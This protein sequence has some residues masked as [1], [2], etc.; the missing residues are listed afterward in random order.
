[1]KDGITEV[2]TPKKDNQMQEDRVQ[3]H[4]K[5]L[6][7]QAKD[8][9]K[10]DPNAALALLSQAIAQADGIG[11]VTGRAEAIRLQGQIH[12]LVGNPEKA[13]I[14]FNTALQQFQAIEYEQGIAECRNNLGQLYLHQNKYDAALE[15]IQ[16]SLT[17][18]LELDAPDG[19]ASC[20][21]TLAEICHIRDDYQQE[22]KYL[23]E[24]MS[25]VNRCLDK[26]ILYLYLV[27]IG[28][29]YTDLGEYDQS[30]VY[31]LQVIKDAENQDYL[32]IALSKISKVYNLT[33]ELQ[34]AIDCAKEALSLAIQNNDRK[35]QAV[36]L[37]ELAKGYKTLQDFKQSL[38]YLEK[39]L[40]IYQ[41]LHDQYSE[42]DCLIQKASL[43]KYLGDA[44]ESD[45]INRQAYMLA[46]EINHKEA[47][48]RTLCELGASLNQQ[49]K[50]LESTKH[51]EL[52]LELMDDKP[53]PELLPNLYRVLADNYKQ[54]RD[55]E[56]SL[57]FYQKYHELSLEETEMKP[58]AD[59][60]E[61]QNSSQKSKIESPE[62][63]L[64]SDAIINNT[65][66]NMQ[67]EP[68]KSKDK[69]NNDYLL[70][71]K[72]ARIGSWHYNIENHELYI[73]D[74]L[75][76]M[77]GVRDIPVK[78]FSHMLFSRIN[79][80]DRKQLYRYLRDLLKNHKEFEFQFQISTANAK[81]LVVIAHGEPLYS[82][83]GELAGCNGTLQDVTDKTSL[84]NKSMGYGTR[85]QSIIDALPDI[86]FIFDLYGNYTDIMLSS[87]REDFDSIM[88]LKGKNIRDVCSVIEAE[89]YMRVIRDTIRSEKMQII[90]Y[91]FDPVIERK[92][93]EGRTALLKDEQSGEPKVI[94]VARDITQLKGI[95]QDL[96]QLNNELESRISDRTSDL[97]QAQLELE[98]E[99]E[100]RKKS[101]DQ[102]QE[103]YAEQKALFSVIPAIVYYKDKNLKYI[104]ANQAFCDVFQIKPDEVNG[105]TDYD[106]FPPDMAKQ[107]QEEDRKILQGNDPPKESV[108]KLPIR[109]GELRWFSTA[110]TSYRN[111]A[112]EIIAIVGVSSD[113]TE[114]KDQEAEL[115]RLFTAIEQSAGTV[116]ITDADGLIRYV[117]P[118]FLSITG[119][120][121]DEVLGKNPRFLKS[122][123]HDNVF[124][125]EMWRAIKSGLVWKG[126]FTNQRKDGLIF[127][128]EATISPVKDESG[129][130]ISFVKVSR[131][132]TRENMLMLQLRQSQKMESIGTLAGGIAHDFNNILGAIM[133]Y[134]ELIADDLPD[135]SQAAH[136][137]AQVM[138]AIERAR[139]LVNQILTFSKMAETECQSLPLQPII[140][141]VVKLLRAS[142]PSTIEIRQN[143]DENAPTTFADPSQIH[144]ILMNLCTNAAAAMQENGGVLTIS[145]ERANMSERF[146]IDREK[147]NGS[148][149][150]LIISDTGVG[151]PKALLERIFDPFFTT[152]APGLGTGLG[153]SVVHG[154]VSG[155]GGKIFVESTEGAGTTFTIFLKTDKKITP[156]VEV[157]PH[158][159]DVPKGKEHI[160]VVDDEAFIT[161]IMKQ[162][163]TRLGYE[164]TA[165]TDSQAALALLIA[166]TKEF[167]LLITDLTMPGMTGLELAELSRKERPNLPIILC[168]GFNELKNTDVYKIG[169]REV[170]KKPIDRMKLAE[171]TRKIL[172]EIK[173]DKQN[174]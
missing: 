49:F 11:Y 143:I 148:Y 67:K 14:H 32:I 106:L 21:I 169:I 98:N 123:K 119:Y 39:A 105:L 129:K 61:N 117:N 13:L 122:G 66:V 174:N 134:S 120:S 43:L 173:Q 63:I 89:K 65:P 68:L 135:A 99:L 108:K 166:K 126:V 20:Y 31:L 62:Q 142:V 115:I 91:Q 55:F 35:A 27:N 97:E 130:I 118:A 45:Q 86:T 12:L 154:I 83:D 101:T 125:L 151:I 38:D 24:G 116:C 103:L 74:V 48:I 37:V 22:L 161:D 51:L 77:L 141:D 25:Y 104:T 4:I 163:L 144:Q 53:I 58:G 16:R 33:G 60:I 26:G 18:F 95:N 40:S 50:F 140:K 131:D 121:K 124:Y 156:T 167:D 78:A 47:Q 84:Q 85:L 159:K 2:N 139:D 111:K 138:T 81:K 133:G 75:S 3:K 42:T 165:L 136:N 172:D 71:Q 164:V 162:T 153:L 54:Q 146:F 112:G 155:Y 88:S 114:L 107:I 10:N 46:R 34:K 7:E 90:E 82:E 100:L 56:K 128:E 44:D 158:T 64:K 87:S 30:L 9:L 137:M 171:I 152:K 15:Q 170:L 73:S 17:T 168:S 157:K 36:S 79:S 69:K 145:L 1:M 149:L 150:K 5:D 52:V 113:V 80:E 132:V 6:L 94:W 23:F 109:S 28:I 59:V 92:W 76:D 72:I 41:E 102:L 29:A 147:P 96:A 8:M 19:I 160:L 110:Q 70:S 93:Y 127:E 57:I